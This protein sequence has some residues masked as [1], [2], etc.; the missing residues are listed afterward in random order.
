MLYPKGAKDSQSAEVSSLQL[1]T[2][3]GVEERPRTLS[4]SLSLSSDRKKSGRE[5]MTSSSF[6]T[7]CFRPPLSDARN[8]EQAGPSERGMRELELFLDDVHIGN[9]SDG[10]K[11]RRGRRNHQRR[12]IVDVE[13]LRGGGRAKV[14]EQ[15]RF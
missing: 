4:L 3:G 7:S 10:E 13:S 15:P 9:S 11:Q 12:Q 14:S 6:S 2:K 5:S 8:Q 1:S